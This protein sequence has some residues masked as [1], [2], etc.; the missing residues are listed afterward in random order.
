M[1]GVIGVVQNR[2]HRIPASAGS[3]GSL[4]RFGKALGVRVTHRKFKMLDPIKARKNSLRCTEFRSK[5]ASDSGLCYVHDSNEH[6]RKPPVMENFN[7]A[8]G[9]SL[10]HEL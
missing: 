6:A 5:A 3:C 4:D 9:H 1:D 8:C 2:V 10:S 7:D